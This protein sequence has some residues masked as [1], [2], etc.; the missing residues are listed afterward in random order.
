M[1]LSEGKA[2]KP[3]KAFK[4]NFWEHLKSLGKKK[5]THLQM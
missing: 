4:M 5:R 3:L 2:V 1:S